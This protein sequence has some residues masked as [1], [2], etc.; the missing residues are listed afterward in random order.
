ME[1]QALLD[2]NR[3]EKNDGRLLAFF[4]SGQGCLDAL[5]GSENLKLIVGLKICR[6]ETVEGFEGNCAWAVD[7]T[8][9]YFW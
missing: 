9:E 8:I 2:S 1:R 7:Q 3:G 5:N 6:A 4:E